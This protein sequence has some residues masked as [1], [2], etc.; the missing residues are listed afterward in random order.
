[1]L[2]PPRVVRRVGREIRQEILL[3]IR[4]EIPKEERPLRRGEAEPV[5]LLA[6]AWH[7]APAAPP[8]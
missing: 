6:V 7:P 1:M 2:H 8:R 5:A 4:L 3:E